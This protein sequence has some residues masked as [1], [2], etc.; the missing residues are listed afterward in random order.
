MAIIQEIEQIETTEE[1]IP[2]EDDGNNSAKAHIVKPG[3]EDMSAQDVVDLAR[4]AGT[5]V[6]ALCGYK[7]VPKRDPKKHDLC[8]VCVKIW[9]SI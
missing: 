4:L 9:E 2:Y 3:R 7:W 5:E 6:T 8:K 1:I